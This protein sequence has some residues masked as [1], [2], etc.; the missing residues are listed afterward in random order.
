M[1]QCAI[2]PE[3][4]MA[5]DAIN[6]TEHTEA[7]ALLFIGHQFECVRVCRKFRGASVCV[8]FVCEG[9]RCDRLDHVIESITREWHRTR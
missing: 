9:F 4:L 1:L 3:P 5:A 6:Q 2:D 7:F 8:V